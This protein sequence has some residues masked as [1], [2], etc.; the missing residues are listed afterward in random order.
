LPGY[1]ADLRNPEPLALGLYFIASG[2]LLKNLSLVLNVAS[3]R[4]FNLR[5]ENMNLLK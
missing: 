1:I 3:G 2:D 4:V 5:E